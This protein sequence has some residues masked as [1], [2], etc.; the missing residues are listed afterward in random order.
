[1]HHGAYINANFAAIQTSLGMSDTDLWQM[2]RNGFTSAFISDEQRQR[3]LMEIDAH[4]P[5][6][7]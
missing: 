5:A 6:V 1:M 2:A 4:R 7:V 3:Y